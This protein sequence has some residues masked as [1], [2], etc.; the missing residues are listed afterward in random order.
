ML[1]VYVSSVIPAPIDKAWKLVRDFNG[2]PSWSHMVKVSRIEDGLPA[3]K[4]GCIRNFIMH[5]GG[6]VIEQLVALSDPEYKLSYTIIKIGIP[7]KNYLSTIRLRPITD[8]NQTF[9]EWSTEFDVTEP[10]REQE[11]MKFLAN[12][13]YLASMHALTKALKGKGK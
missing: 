10:G 7:V 3:D 4:V 6:N 5:D 9:M 13:V 2:L 1:K 11:M 12:D 8:G